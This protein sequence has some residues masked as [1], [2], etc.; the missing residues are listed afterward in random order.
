MVA[1][2]GPR[3]RLMKE[4]LQNAA[5]NIGKSVNPIRNFQ[6]LEN[7]PNELYVILCI[8]EDADKQTIKLAYKKLAMEYH[9]DQNPNNP[10]AVAEFQ[11]IQAA[12]EI[13]ANPE[14]KKIYDK[15]GRDAVERYADMKNMTPEQVQ[16]FLAEQNMALILWIFACVLVITLAFPVLLSYRLDNDLGDTSWL[17]IFIPVYVLLGIVFFFFHLGFLG[18]LIC[19]PV[20]TEDNAE[21]PPFLKGKRRLLLTFLLVGLPLYCCLSFSIMLPLRLNGSINYAWR[22]IFIPIYYL[23]I[24]DFIQAVVLRHRRIKHGQKHLVLPAWYHLI[25]VV[26]KGAMLGLFVAKLDDDIAAN[27]WVIAVPVYIY[28]GGAIL[29]ACGSAFFAFKNAKEVI[30]QQ[31]NGAATY[32]EANAASNEANHQFATACCAILPLS[33]CFLVFLLLLVVSL[34]VDHLKASVVLI[35]VWVTYGCACCCVSSSL[36]AVSL[37]GDDAR[38]FE[39][40][41]T[42]DISQER[43]AS[44]RTH[45]H[46]RIRVVDDDAGG[47]P[48]DTA[49]TRLIQPSGGGSGMLSNGVVTSSV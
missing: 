38:P 27:W 25:W 18:A 46:I 6:Q 39:D 7:A 49:D 31:E 11:E 12:Y 28:T 4:R 29:A 22:Y 26:L 2:E 9:P 47:I 37:R 42:K 23:P 44:K 41:E 19:S 21:M 20:P 33:C 35:P 30:R 24:R 10:D 43:G 40:D 45:S 13:L 48:D 34:Q 15:F 8:P 17:V 1:N 36:C 5:Q 14:K 3:T 32:D 16:L